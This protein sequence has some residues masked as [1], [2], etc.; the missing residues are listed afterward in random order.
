[1]LAKNVVVARVTS[2][3]LARDHED[4]KARRKKEEKKGAKERKL[5]KKDRSVSFR[6]TFE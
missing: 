4:G 2:S 5:S 1:M 3:Y 6:G